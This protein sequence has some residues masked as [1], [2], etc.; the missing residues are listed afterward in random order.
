MQFEEQATRVTEHGAGFVAAPERRRRRLTVGAYG[1][2]RR[3]QWV[4]WYGM[5][6]D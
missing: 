4:V 5:H 6:A 2:L 3:C 1:R